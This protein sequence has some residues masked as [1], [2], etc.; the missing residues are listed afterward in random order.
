MG[1]F[2]PNLGAATTH[3]GMAVPSATD[4]ETLFNAH[5]GSGVLSG[6][7]VAGK[8]TPA[9]AVKISA[10]TMM[11]KRLQFPVAAVASL[12]I[13]AASTTDR[14]DLVVVS[15]TGTAT[16]TKGT[17]C[18]VATWT[19][20]S[21]P[22]KAPVAPTCPATHIPLA[23]VYVAHST[24]T[25]VT[26]N[27]S[28]PGVTLP[29]PVQG[30]FGVPGTYWN[31]GHY[32]PVFS[33]TG[34]T[35]SKALPCFTFI[36]FPVNVGRR[37]TRIAIACGAPTPGGVGKSR[38][39]IYADNGSGKPGKVVLDAGQVTLAGAGGTK[40]LTITKRLYPGMYWLAQMSETTGSATTITYYCV[41][42]NSNMASLGGPSGATT[43][44]P[45][46]GSYNY[47]WEATGV[48]GG[49]PTT[50]TSIISTDDNV[51]FIC[52]RAAAT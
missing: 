19:K 52:V 11:W 42:E 24:T 16:V 35:S 7:V 31:T 46:T 13:T 40:I 3:N 20:T 23:Q 8:T 15:K 5:A 21:T 30:I 10:G 4:I 18:G 6:C 17:P 33:G 48:S 50:P 25:I 36:P 9:M 38:L 27:L 2:I 45:R 43:G 47:G 14:V 32:Y 49:L 29:A 12:T 44:V 28:R 39:G 37:F 26:A 41:P 51:P 22:T 34:K 1:N